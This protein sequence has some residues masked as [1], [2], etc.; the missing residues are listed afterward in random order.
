MQHTSRPPTRAAAL[1]R[2]YEM[3]SKAKEVGKL[4]LTTTAMEDTG[5]YSWLRAMTVA[6]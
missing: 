5:V 1:W 3:L 2:R 6:D 4:A